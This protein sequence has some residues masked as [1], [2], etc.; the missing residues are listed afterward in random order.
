MTALLDIGAL[1]AA[2]AGF[3]ALS[4]AMDRHWAQLRGRG[5]APAKAQRRRL[6]G[7]G[8]A[9]LL[10]SLLACLAARGGAQ[11]WVD[12]AG[13]LTAAAMA[14]VLLL[15]YGPR[16]LALLG[17]GSGAAALAIILAAVLTRA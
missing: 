5:A 7:A 8:A 14:V 13:V 16:R 6:R 12:W 10:A 15:T 1:C 4:L 2:L 11:G 17:W 3:I 9:G